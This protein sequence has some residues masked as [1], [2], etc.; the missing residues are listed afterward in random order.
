ME[1]PRP[2]HDLDGCRRLHAAMST[3]ICTGV[4]SWH[5]VH[6]R[7]PIESRAIDFI[8]VDPGRAEA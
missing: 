4:K 1:D 7:S 6:Y 8:R 3:P 2:E 5:A